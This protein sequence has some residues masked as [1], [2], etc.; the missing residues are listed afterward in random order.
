MLK[1]H[2]MIYDLS[3]ALEIE[4]FYADLVNNLQ[5]YRPRLV[6]DLY[7]FLRKDPYRAI[8]MVGFKTIDIY[9]LHVDKCTGTTAIPKDMTDMMPIVVQVATSWLDGIMI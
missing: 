7:V 5:L 8:I 1:Q 9:R 2:D 6:K 4:Q 3:C